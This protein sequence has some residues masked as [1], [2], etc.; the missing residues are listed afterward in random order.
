MQMHRS[1]QLAFKSAWTISH[2]DPTCSYPRW[3][4]RVW[5]SEVNS[6]NAL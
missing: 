2:E 1:A 4:I 6:A 3:P 5:T